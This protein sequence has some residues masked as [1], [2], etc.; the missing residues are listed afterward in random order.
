MNY[1]AALTATNGEPPYTWGIIA[2]Q[3]PPGLSLQALTG[4][5]S[6]APTQAGA[7]SFQAQVKDSTGETTSSGFNINTGTA[8]SPIVRGVSPNSGPPSGGTPVTLSGSNFQA[9]ATVLFG[10][11]TASS[12]TASSAT[13]IQAV[14][15][16]HLAGTVDITVR[17]PDAQ[18]STLAS[19]F[20]Y[21]T[22]PSA[23]LLSGMT[24]ANFTMP[25]GWTLVKAQDFESGSVGGSESI[26][27]SITGSNPHGG[28]KSLAGTYAGDGATVAYYLNSGVTGSFSELYLSF[29]DF[30]E[31]Q[32]RANDELFI[33]R[34]F[35]RDG[36]GNL[37]QEV[38]ID[39]LGAGNSSSNTGFNS[40]SSNIVIEPQSPSSGTTTAIWGP[41][42]ELGWGTW[43]QWEIEFKPNSPGNSDGLIRVYKNGALFLEKVNIKL[44]GNLNMNDAGVEVGG[45][46]TKLT[47]IRSDGSCG[48]FLGD[49]TDSGPR[50]S[51][52]NH[53]P[54][55]NQGPPSGVVPIFKRMIDDVIVIKK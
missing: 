6:G 26:N 12:V 41:G 42:Y 3:L 24:P 31:A 20:T 48:S 37:A 23:G 7:F 45:V 49:G 44:N 32:G 35:I 30:M 51:N 21:T 54:C 14:A 10:G 47:W 34:F 22:Q 43:T 11:V 18:S 53:L 38:I 46:Y 27:G 15:P 39:N 36:S 13:Q 25:S 9:G 16:A 8:S 55:P 17:N 28:S 4:Q 40:L 50:V 33:A 5:I 1:S 2:G 52:F 29:Y 19:G